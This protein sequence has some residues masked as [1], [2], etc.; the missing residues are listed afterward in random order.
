MTAPT[1]VY[2]NIS[3][4]LDYERHLLADWGLSEALTLVDVKAPDNEPATFLEAAR[5][6]DGVVVEYFELTG[7]VIARL[8]R[9]KVAA[10]QAIGSSN[11]DAE[12]AT[13]A[14]VCVTNAP[15]FCVEEVALHTVGLLIDLVR[16]ISYL[17]RRVRAGE[18]EPLS[19]PIPHRV[20]GKTMGLAFFGAIPQGMV[21]L[22]TAMGLRIVAWAPTK[23]AEFLAE[24]GVEKAETL[25]ALLEQSDV[26][27]LHTPL[28]PQTHHLI[29]ARELALMR[30]DAYLI[31]TARGKVVDEPAL[32]AAL[33]SGQ[34]AGAGIDVIE[35]EDS[36]QT[37]LRTLEN[38]VITPHAAFLSEESFLEAREIALRQLVQRLVEGRRPQNLV[39]RDVVWETQR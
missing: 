8:P 18:W 31:N 19:G 27:S 37:E 14:G 4:T 12:A 39:N 9:L 1:V 5:D 20:T 38:V 28:L 7:D 11:I 10:V 23:S 3:D 13:A 22:L 16:K 35:D 33:R 2:F 26:V 36:E 15:G 30:P 29:G 6:A 21:P 34:I 17:D 25:D 24:F 32:V